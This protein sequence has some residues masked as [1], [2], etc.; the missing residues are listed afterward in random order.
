MTFEFWKQILYLKILCCLQEHQLTKDRK[1][2]VNKRMPLGENYSP[3]SS[4]TT[5]NQIKL[6]GNDARAVKIVVVDS[7]NVQKAGQGRGSSARRN[8][9]M[10]VIRSISKGESSHP[11]PP[12]QR[13][14]T[15]THSPSYIVMSY[16]SYFVR[17][18]IFR[19]S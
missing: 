10:G 15:G 3:P 2:N 13:R 12:R 14:K 17:M 11:K 6:S 16:Q 8:P 7:Q 4:T 9:N 5:S 1:K 18:T 19:R